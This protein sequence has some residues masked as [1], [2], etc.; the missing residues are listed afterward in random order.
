MVILFNIIIKKI[1]MK[2]KKD[3]IEEKNTKFRK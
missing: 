2:T 1:K 3:T